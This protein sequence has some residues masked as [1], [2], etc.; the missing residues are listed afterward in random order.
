MVSKELK[1]NEEKKA[2]KILKKAVYH[3]LEYDSCQTRDRSHPKPHDPSKSLHL[4]K[5]F[6]MSQMS[7]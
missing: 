6:C 1:G 2:L 5:K 7:R 4:N 3:R